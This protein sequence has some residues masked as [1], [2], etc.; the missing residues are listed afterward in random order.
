MLSDLEWAF[1]LRPS[2]AWPGIAPRGGCGWRSRLEPP[3]EL[4]VQPH[5]GVVAAQAEHHQHR[6]LADAL[7]VV[8][9]E[10]DPN[11]LQ[12]YPRVEVPIQGTVLQDSECDVELVV[13]AAQVPVGGPQLPIADILVVP[14]SG[15]ILCIAGDRKTHEGLVASVLPLAAA[16]LWRVP[17]DTV[18]ASRTC[19]GQLVGE[20]G[21]AHVDL[22]HRMVSKDVEPPLGAARLG[23]CEIQQGRGIAEIADDPHADALHVKRR[24]GLL[25]VARPYVRL[26]EGLDGCTDPAGLHAS[27]AL[28]HPLFVCGAHPLWSFRSR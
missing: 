8:F 11:R 21:F 25:S 26:A 28:S 19:H 6:D 23:G 15:A 7:Q 14:A 4:S 13:L 3:L 16:A 24:G 18:Q 17:D 2:V 12:R 10:R 22:D 5:D 27:M 9:L 1:G 20:P